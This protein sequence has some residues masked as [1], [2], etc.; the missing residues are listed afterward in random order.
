MLSHHA[1]IH[2][3]Y[4]SLVNP[5]FGYSLKPLHVFYLF[6]AEP[7]EIKNLSTFVIAS[8]IV[9]QTKEKSL[10]DGKPK[11]VKK[12]HRQHGKQKKRERTNGR[13]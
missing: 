12:V 8:R 7:D 5:V 2:V 13:H 1:F 6:A 10:K 3:Y 11:Y 9:L 4:L